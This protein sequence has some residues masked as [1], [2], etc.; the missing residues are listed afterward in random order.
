MAVTQT[1]A[2]S[3]QTGIR[4]YNGDLTDYT[5]MMGG[6]VPDVH[7]LRSLSPETT[8]RTIC[9][10]YRGPWFLM[11]YFGS[12][13]NA[14][15]N[16]PFATYKKVI[17]YYNMGIQISGVESSLNSQPLQGG[18][19]GRSIN[20]PTVQ[21][22]NNNQTLTIT[23]PE[24]QGRPIANFHNMWVDGISD[25]ITGLTH[26]H[27][28]VSGSVDA[29][30]DEPKRI[31][32]SYAGE[33]SMALEPSMAWEV[34]EFLLI[35]LDRSGARVEGAIMALGCIP[36]AKVGFNIFDQNATGNSQI[37]QLQLT[38]NCQ[39]IQ[40]AFVNDLAARYVRQFAVFGNS[41]NLNPGAGD[42]FFDF[43][44]S[45]TQNPNGPINTPQFNHGYRPYLDGVQS[46]VGNAP[47]FKADQQPI[48]R[49]KKP[50][51]AVQPED[52]S[53]IYHS[54]PADTF[55][56]VNFPDWQQTGGHV[57]Q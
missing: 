15:T 39:F 40:S 1:D 9:V 30:T 13:T 27:G 7:T 36:A 42:A 21:N 47:V 38:Y 41:L 33:D 12:G 50:V 16:R 17:E 8:N 29:E 56:A 54:A 34:A 48:E 25:P 18:F 35:A 6:L 31:F 44:Q 28:L 3:L 10:M 26:Y 55:E 37:Q 52:H 14:Y 22:T 32:K 51:T 53:R 45:A 4:D 20:I 57:N 11:H 43:K 24:L 49:A 19:A 23:V 2:V 46:D 5:G